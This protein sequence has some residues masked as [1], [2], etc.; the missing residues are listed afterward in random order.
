[1]AIRLRIENIELFQPSSSANPK[2]L[3][4]LNLK[5][6]KLVGLFS[7]DGAESIFR[8]AQLS[9]QTRNTLFDGRSGNC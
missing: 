7:F 6:S 4:E 9:T 5:S 3:T 1:V 2:Q 8:E